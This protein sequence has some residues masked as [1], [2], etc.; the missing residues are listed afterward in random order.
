MGLLCGLH[1]A[2]KAVVPSKADKQVCT[3][4][5]LVLAHHAMQRAYREFYV[6]IGGDDMDDETHCRMEAFTTEW[7]DDAAPDDAREINTRVLAA[8]VKRIGCD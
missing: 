8:L 5:E 2:E 4:R 7:R 6:S 1:S 3:L